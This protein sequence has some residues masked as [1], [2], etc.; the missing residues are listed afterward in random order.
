MLL[1]QFIHFVLEGLLLKIFLEDLILNHKI[2]LLDL[3]FI[4]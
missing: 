3:R 4:P 2:F 1:S